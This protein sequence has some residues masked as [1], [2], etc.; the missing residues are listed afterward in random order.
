MSYELGALVPLSVT[1]TDEDGNPANATS[2][3]LTLTLPD[4]TAD[5][6]ANVS[7]T[8][9]GVYEVDYPTVQAG[10]HGVR[11]VATGVNASV[12][13]DVFTVEPVDGGAFV[14]MLDAKRHMKKKLITVD[15]D[16]ELAGFVDAACQMIVDR[17]GPVSPTSVVD[18]VHRRH[19]RVV[20]LSQ[21]P[22]IDVTAVQIPGGDAVPA[23]D[24][25]NA[26]DGWELDAGAGLL[27]HT[28]CWPYGRLRVTYRAGRTPVPGH[29]RL[30]ALELVAHLW[31]S[32]KIQT[33]GG[34]AAPPGGDDVM[35]VGSSYAL[36]NRVRELLGLTA[37]QPTSGVMVR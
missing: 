26:V 24:L 32:I 14:S 6:H 25:D 15:D 36:P 11:W 1:I 31:R 10:R 29:V 9:T 34:R 21:H 37:D 12:Y 2:V 33:A 5:V 7:P 8:E 28:G 4:G 23:A 18:A 30:A 20:A 27:T 3:T 16:D 35:L 13:T 19:G 22:V 17:I